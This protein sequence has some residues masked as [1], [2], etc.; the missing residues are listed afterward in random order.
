MLINQPKR[1]L[2]SSQECSGLFSTMSD[3]SSHKITL[4]K[5]QI[6]RGD[7]QY[8]GVAKRENAG[9]VTSNES[10]CHPK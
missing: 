5:F 4:G 9:I 10:R 1:R 6:E 2:I 8:S 3:K 7:D